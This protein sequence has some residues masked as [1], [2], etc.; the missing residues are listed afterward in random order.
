MTHDIPLPYGQ[1]PK[2]PPRCVVCETPNPGTIAKIT[3]IIAVQTQG[4]GADLVDMAIGD[5][6]RASKNIKVTL[7]PAACQGCKSSLQH[8]HLWKQ[9]WQYLGPLLGV[10]LFAFCA[11]KNLSF[12]GVV[13]LMAGIIVPVAYE[14][15][16]PAA[17]SATG[18][19][20]TVIYEFKSQRCAQEFAELNQDHRQPEDP[21]D[22]SLPS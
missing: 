3:V 5:A 14:M 22:P 20:R 8:Y 10:A 1:Q 2:F 13:A 16:F 15:V 18:S 9:I 21:K 6:S 11:V 4:L 19:G 17:L 7:E 12:L